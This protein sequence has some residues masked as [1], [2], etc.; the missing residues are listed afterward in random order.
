M[1]VPR[2]PISASNEPRRRG[3]LRR[4]PAVTL[5]FALACAGLDPL[6]ADAPSQPTPAQIAHA[7][8][9]V[10][11]QLRYAFSLAERGAVFSANARFI[12]CL[13]TVTPAD[14]P[15]RRLSSGGPS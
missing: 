4:L 10:Q 11:G 3:N 15:D 8:E 5:A 9:I 13:E 14:A 6:A 12:E 2:D 1:D 7:D